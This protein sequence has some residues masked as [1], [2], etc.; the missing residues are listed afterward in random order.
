MI[1]PE[2][3][4]EMPLEVRR[5]AAARLVAEA[6]THAALIMGPGDP[7]GEEYAAIAALLA[8]PP[9]LRGLA[10]G[11]PPARA[12]P[13]QRPLLLLHRTPPPE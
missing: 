13:G 11:R 2:E 3:F 1:D 10:P 5:R 12:R 7:D 8:P 9:P 6:A 4:A